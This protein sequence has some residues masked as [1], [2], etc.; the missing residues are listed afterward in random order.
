VGQ[1]RH[2]TLSVDI[3]AMC[4]G[5]VL[6]FH[7]VPRQAASLGKFPETD[8]LDREGFR[9]YDPVLY[10]ASLKTASNQTVA[11][12][13]RKFKRYEQPAKAIS[14]SVGLSRFG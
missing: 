8:T 6:T 5:I 7:N 9:G 12:I 1:R 11:R 13:T 10:Y 14:R 2:L 3:M 4:D